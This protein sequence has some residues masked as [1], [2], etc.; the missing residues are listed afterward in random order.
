M[1]TKADWI[2]PHWRHLFKHTLDKD[3]QV[4]PESHIMRVLRVLLPLQRHHPLPSL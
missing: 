2:S 1:D 4:Q 3:W